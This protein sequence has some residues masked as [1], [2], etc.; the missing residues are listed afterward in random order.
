M[1]AFNGG[2]LRLADDVRY[3]R[4]GDQVY[5]RR[6]D[7][8]KDYLFNGIAEDILSC[9]DGGASLESDVVLDAL[10]RQYEIPDADAFRE[11]MLGF[12]RLL[13][14]ESILVT[15][16]D[17]A[18]APS[19]R[20]QVT[21]WCGQNRA[22]FSACLE[23]TYR[24]NERCV[25]CYVDDPDRSRE[26]LTTDEWKGVVDQLRAMGCM[27]LL[28]T[29]GEVCVKEGFIDIA[30]YASGKGMLVDIYSNGL[31]I[32]DDLF[33]AIVALKPNSLSFS[34]YAGDAGTHDAIT[35]VKGSFERTVRAAM[36]TR[37]A[38]IDTYIKTVVMRENA[39][40]IE[41]LMRLGKRLNIPVTPAFVIMDTHLGRPGDAHRLS[42]VDEYV[43]IMRMVERYT[44]GLL[45]GGARDPNAFNCSAGHSTLSIDPFGGVHPCNTL[46]LSCGN[47]R[48][49]PLETIW[50]ESPALKALHCLR[51][52]DV[53]AECETCE[54][55]DQCSVC[56]GR[57]GW[58]QG[59]PVTI[60]DEICRVARAKRQAR[61]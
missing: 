22:L 5:L 55:S 24:C 57:I 15:R 6:I 23:L 47:V 40:G 2:A 59:K 50:S 13:C 21:Q 36:M 17:G 10:A 33:D 58:E 35:K 43:D 19:V 46:S 41:G 29:G 12:L 51:I 39:H 60:P 9:F 53:C 52:K 34:L 56:L 49:T 16:A 45:G 1:Q 27:S 48:E 26:E 28:L 31:A 32:D 37:C 14:D 30:R 42:A 11:D 25:H 8:R 54:A 7:A 4:Y 3:G 18:P 20:D 38:G 61:M 44:P